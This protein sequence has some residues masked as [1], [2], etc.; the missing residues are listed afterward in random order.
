[1]KR[2]DHALRDAVRARVPM[3]TRRRVAYAR[4]AARRAAPLPRILPA[5]LI[6]G[7]QRGGTSSLY[8]YLR[9]HPDV[10]G[11]LRKEVAYFTSSYHEG[12]AWYRAHFP[13]AARDRIHGLRRGRPLMGLEATPDYLL[14][15]RAAARAVAILPEARIVVLLRDPVDRAWSHWAHMR[16]LGIETLSFDEALAA[17]PRRLG[18]ALDR[19]AEVDPLDRDRDEPLPRPVLRYSYVARG[20]YGA[21]L[22][23]WLARYPRDRILVVRSE[24]FYADTPRVFA[25]IVAFLGLPEWLPDR[26]SNI[27]RSGEE[28]AAFELPPLDALS[29]RRLAETFVDDRERVERLIGKDFWRLEGVS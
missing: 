7:A 16:R 21:Q 25:S 4:L 27:S 11:A 9:R 22:E 28:R 18:G 13:L 20:R 17:E 6:I 15:P 26:F 8:T 29:R 12:I 24:E 3:R 2:W 23:R 5:V 19:L 14:D 10:A 1:M